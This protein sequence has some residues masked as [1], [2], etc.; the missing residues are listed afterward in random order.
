MSADIPPLFIYMQL[1]WLFYYESNKLLYRNYNII[2]YVSKMNKEYKVNANEMLNPQTSS[3][4][5]HCADLTQSLHLFSTSNL[6][7]S[8]T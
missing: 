3:I 8:D 6:S 5:D 1:L 2:S 4:P 7:L